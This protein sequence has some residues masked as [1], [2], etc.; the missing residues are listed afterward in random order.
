MSS[1]GNNVKYYYIPVDNEIDRFN[2]LLSV[3]SESNINKSLI[4]VSSE[5]INLLYSKLYF[6]DFSSSIVCSKYHTKYTNTDLYRFIQGETR[7]LITDKQ[8]APHI[9]I[10]YLSLV[11]Y[12]NLTNTFTVDNFIHNI[13]SVL[14]LCPKNR[15]DDFLGSKENICFEEINISDFENKLSQ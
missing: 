13:G 6:N 1:S 12:Y 15:I 9:K 4:Y 7:V 3:F 10:P 14:V 11:I 8:V 2:T 5:K